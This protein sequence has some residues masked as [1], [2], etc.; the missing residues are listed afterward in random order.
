MTSQ[1]RAV[2]QQLSSLSITEAQY[3]Q[4]LQVL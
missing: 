3:M 1:L 4:I 2:R